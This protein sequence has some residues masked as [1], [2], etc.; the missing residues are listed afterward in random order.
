[1]PTTLF[2]LPKA[3][4]SQ[5]VKLYPDQVR[6]TPTIPVCMLVTIVNL[7]QTI[8]RAAKAACKG[9]RTALL[10]LEHLCTG[11]RNTA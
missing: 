6:S 9:L 7:A 4:Y 8:I 5:L 11:E 2:A 10:L 3:D 1:M